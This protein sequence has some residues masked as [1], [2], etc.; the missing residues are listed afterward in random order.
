MKRLN[1]LVAITLLSSGLISAQTLIQPEVLSDFTQ[2]RLKADEMGH[3]EIVAH[4]TICD[5]KMGY[6]DEAITANMEMPDNMKA[7]LECVNQAAQF[8]SEN[9][10]L[11]MGTAYATG[12]V[13]KP[14][15]GNIK[16]DQS[17]PFNNLCPSGT[18]V[19]CVAT[20]MAQVMYYYRY[21]EHGYGQH[22]YSY[23]GVD[24]HVDFEATTYQW[25]LMYDYYNRNCTDEQNFEV[26]Q[27]SYHCGVAADMQYAP[28]GS[29]A[30]T[31]YLPDAMYNYFGY[32][33]LAACV[34]RSAYHY[35][36]WTELLL[37][38]LREGRPIIFSG[39][40]NEVGH[41][42]VVD[43]YNAEGLFHVNW[44][45]S[46]YYNGYFDIGILNPEGAGIGGAVDRLG[47]CL[48]QNALVQL[49]PEEGTGKRY[50]PILNG[51]QF[52]YTTIGE[53]ASTSFFMNAGLQNN[54]GRSVLC[55]V[56]VAIIDKD[57]APVS[58]SNGTHYKFG[59][60]AKRN[61]WQWLQTEVSVDQLPDGVYTAELYFVDDTYPTDTILMPSSLYYLAPII[62]IEDNCVASINGYPE[63]IWL[64][65]TNFNMADQQI[66]AVGRKY[67]FTLDV[68]NVS[69]HTFCGAITLM[70]QPRGEEIYF[71]SGDVVLPPGEQMEVHIPVTFDYEDT[72]E[73]WFMAD[74]YGLGGS[75]I[76]EIDNL[77][78]IVTEYNEE[79]PAV[80][81]LATSPQVLTTRCEV[82]GTF[83]LLHN[84]NNL[85]R[86]FDGSL[87][88]RIFSNKS[89]TNN[90]LLTFEQEC[91]LDETSTNNE[92]IVSG[93]LAG[94]TPNAKYYARSYYKDND[95]EYRPL[96]MSNGVQKIVEFKVY[97]A[98][99]IEEIHADKDIDTPVYDLMGR[100]VNGKQ[101]ISIG[102]HGISINR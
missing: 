57:G 84:V 2:L 67:D 20:A 18:P 76:I 56:G 59:S 89:N 95:G 41:C 91:Q 86:R 66:F 7:W 44:G 93:Q 92:V 15:L 81:Q 75:S 88:V 30:W 78:T 80:M 50:C 11:T 38:E 74:D 60:Y 45:W 100:R 29:G 82:D 79:S 31:E 85:S 87:V 47:Y 63:E 73:L 25:D 71:S 54:S 22:S 55:S 49:C 1:M 72:W 51:S 99:G 64:S 68:T 28:G 19:G 65:A 23:N 96:T 42:F 21:P 8:V 17:A 101:P 43:G 26:A 32:N 6:T 37:N 90:V 70:A 5:K 98:T 36:D 62:E 14:L 53:T 40:N 61:Y 33:S 46:G 69:E 9:P 34:H 77:G 83:E 94:L 3:A 16:W 58:Y 35:E 13:I 4:T 24:H 52:A 12:E 39:T 48:G 10:Q 97:N 27:L 102:Q